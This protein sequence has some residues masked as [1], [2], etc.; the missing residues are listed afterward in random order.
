[1]AT[2]SARVLSGLTRA[3]MRYLG[4]VADIDSSL[5]KQVT[6]NNPIL[7]IRNQLCRLRCV[8]LNQMHM[9]TLCCLAFP[10]SQTWR[11]SGDLFEKQHNHV[12][13]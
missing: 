11:R 8:A 4:A 3:T 12:L 13:S 2:V 7:Q 9:P 5:V 1:M 6:T 10:P